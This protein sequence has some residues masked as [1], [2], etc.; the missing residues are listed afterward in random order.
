MEFLYIIF[1][2]WFIQFR[3][4]STW[5]INNN[6]S[7]KI[8]SKNNGKVVNVNKLKDKIDVDYNFARL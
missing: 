2:Y 3:N 1:C 4:K 8:E 6:I 5:K 7:I